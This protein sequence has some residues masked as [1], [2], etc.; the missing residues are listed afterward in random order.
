MTRRAPRPPRTCDAPGCA[1]VVPRGKLM[2]RDHWYATPRP[3][4]QEISAAWKEGRI[5]DWS[6]N[7]LSARSFHAGTVPALAESP[8]R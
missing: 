7:C 3:L 4:R 5:R 8:A 6:A 1:I 2:C